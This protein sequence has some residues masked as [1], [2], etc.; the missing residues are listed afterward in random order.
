MELAIEYDVPD[1]GCELSSD[2]Y[3]GFGVGE[4]FGGHERGRLER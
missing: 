4:L 2:W 3:A 1:H